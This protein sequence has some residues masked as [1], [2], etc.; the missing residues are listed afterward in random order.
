MSSPFSSTFAVL[1]PSSLSIV[2]STFRFIASNTAF[3]KSWIL[4]FTSFLFRALITAS[5]LPIPKIPALPFSITS[6]S[7]L[8]LVIS[9]L[10]RA[11]IIA[12]ST[13]LAENST[14]SI[15]SPPVR[16][17]LLFLSLNSRTIFAFE[18]M[19][20]AFALE[21]AADAFSSSSS[22]CA[23]LFCTELPCAGSAIFFALILAALEI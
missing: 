10:M 2:I 13:V 7:S 16:Y 3:R 5:F 12:S 21:R 18:V 15:T 8:S 11:S 6:Y 9:S 23:E 1:L 19:L 17:F 14:N 20:P 22:R 4:S